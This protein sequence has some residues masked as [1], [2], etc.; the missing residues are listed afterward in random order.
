[1]TREQFKALVIA[2]E[3]RESMRESIAV[4]GSRWSHTKCVD[5]RNT[6]RIAVMKAYD[7]VVAQR[8]ALAEVC[9]DLVS[10]YEALDVDLQSLS[11]Q[12]RAALDA[13]EVE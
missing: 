13:L 8:D 2:L 7:E 4:T 9:R 6:A 11:R 10:D 12:A 1:M 3:Y 5:L